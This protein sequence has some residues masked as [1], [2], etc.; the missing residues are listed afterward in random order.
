[1]LEGVPNAGV[2]NVGEVP[3]T[4]EPVPVLVVTTAAA[5]FAEVGAASQA[6]TLAPN[7]LTPVLIGN[8]VAFVKVPLAGVPRTGATKVIP[9]GKVELMLGTP[10]ADVIKTPSFPVGR[11]DT[12]LVL[13]A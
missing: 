4:R 2:T 1:M 10:S 9:E 8:P 6:A 12:A 5:K 7:P 3:K 11:E 13:L